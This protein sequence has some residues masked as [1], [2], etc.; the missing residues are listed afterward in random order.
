MH[1]ENST[2]A[3]PPVQDGP[4]PFWSVMIPTYNGEAY[5]GE[6]L[7]GVLAQDPG[8]RI[9]QIE[10]VD[11]CSTTGDPEALVRNLA[12]DRVDFHR[13]P[14]NVGHSENFN[15]CLRRSRGEV[16][17][18]LHDDDAVR[19]G[20]YARLDP[21]FRDHPD[22][23]AAFT[24][25]L[26]ADEDGHWGSL[27]KLERRTP[28]ILEGWLPRIAS[29]QRI[30][31][32]SIVVR[33]S[34][35]EVLG[36]FDPRIRVGGEDWEM[37]V[38]IASRFAVWFEPQPLAVYRVNRPGSLTGSAEH[39]A[40]LA[41]DMLL[42]TD[43]VGTYLGDHLADHAMVLRRA[44][45][46]YGTWAIGA[47]EDLFRRHR[48]RSATQ[49]VGL[50]FSNAPPASMALASGRRVASALARRVRRRGRGRGEDVRG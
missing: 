33:R 8:R 38:R 50:A 24:R 23:G 6:A 32:P 18:L 44:R 34:A 20:F 42:A 21:V 5:L 7:S 36:G 43:I 39:S 16:V 40:A 25:H 45:I 37:W 41:S 13:Q 26:Y 28:G 3:I 12:G 15:T 17:H 4:R 31:T 2:P 49:A 47:A 27:S 29:G 46:Q 14:R 9:M 48:W 19:P 35:Y 22:V 1:P 10:V 30:A 11:D